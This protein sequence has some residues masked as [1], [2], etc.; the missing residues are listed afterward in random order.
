VANTYCV[1]SSLVTVFSTAM[2]ACTYVGPA[3]EAQ[4]CVCVCKS[5]SW[6]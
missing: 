5:A 4:K 6:G 3:C 2:N 1:V